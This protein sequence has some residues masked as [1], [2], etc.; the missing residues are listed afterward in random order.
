MRET[1]G[2]FLTTDNKDPVKKKNGK[3]KDAE[4]TIIYGIT[5]LRKQRRNLGHMQ[6]GQFLTGGW[7]EKIDADEPV[8][9]AFA[10]RGNFH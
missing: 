7:E 3:A 8:E 10:R 9:L 4:E 6:R 5:S 2:I 1:K